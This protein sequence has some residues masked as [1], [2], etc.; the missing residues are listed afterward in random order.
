M[1]GCEMQKIKDRLNASI[2]QFS[3]NYFVKTEMYNDKNTSDNVKK[4]FESERCARDN[5]ERVNIYSE[6][7]KYDLNIPMIGSSTG[8]NRF[9]GNLFI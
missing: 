7:N 2:L 3:V 4:L 9:C 1:T 5:L 8:L 6:C